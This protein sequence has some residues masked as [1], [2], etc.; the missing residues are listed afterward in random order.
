MG[1]SME[2]QVLVGRSKLMLGFKVEMLVTHSKEVSGRQVDIWYESKVQ[3]ATWT[4]DKILKLLAYQS[5]FRSGQRN[6]SRYL[7]QKLI[8]VLERLK[9]QN[10]RTTTGHHSCNLEVKKLLPLP[11]H[12]SHPWTWERKTKCGASLWKQSCMSNEAAIEKWF[13]FPCCLLFLIYVLIIGR[14]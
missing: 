12:F 6:Y 3:N 7:K 14:T 5:E 11:L 4:E 13:Q 10:S 8:N 1:E 2:E 9:E